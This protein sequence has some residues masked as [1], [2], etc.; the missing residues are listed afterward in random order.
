M[1]ICDRVLRPYIKLCR[2]RISDNVDADQEVL[3]PSVSDDGQG[4]DIRGECMEGRGAEVSVY[5]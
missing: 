1:L 2:M 4:N 3:E 5:C